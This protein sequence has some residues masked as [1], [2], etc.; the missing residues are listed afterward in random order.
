MAA[1]ERRSFKG[2]ASYTITLAGDHNNSVTAITVSDGS[3][4]PDG[5]G[6]PYT[7]TIDPGGTEEKVRVTARSGNTLTVTRAYDGTTAASHVSGVKVVHTIS[8][9]DLDEANQ[10]VVQTIGKVTTAGDMLVG[11]GAGTLSR[12]AAIAKGGLWVS[13]AVGAAPV[14]LPVGSDGQLLRARASASNGLGI[15]YETVKDRRIHTWAISGAPTVT[16]GDENPYPGFQVSIPSGAA[17]TLH[18]VAGVA[19]G[20]TGAPTYKLRRYTGGSWADITG[21]GTT[22]SPLSMGTAAGTG[23]VT[24]PGDA[25]LSDGDVIGLWIVGAGTGT[26]NSFRV[27]VQMDYTPA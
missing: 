17:L 18:G 14:W 21:F 19:P 27:T 9:I 13:T 6:G 26:I 10:T 22:G 5:S 12:V 7:V 16:S 25:S 4:L 23:T 20:A 11:S 2:N 15:Q 3:T 1:Y 8:A 24:A